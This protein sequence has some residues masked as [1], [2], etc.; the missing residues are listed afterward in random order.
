MACSDGIMY[1]NEVSCQTHGPLTAKVCNSGANAGKSYYG[2]Q[3]ECKKFIW[4]DG[5]TFQPINKWGKPLAASS[6]EVVKFMGMES[7]KPV[8]FPKRPAVGT[9]GPPAKKPAVTPTGSSV[10][11]QMLTDVRNT[12]FLKI[13]TLEARVAELESKLAELPTGAATEGEEEQ[14]VEEEQTV[15][16]ESK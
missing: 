4:I 8:T 7:P 3:K 11:S 2:C 13:T 6:K 14:P 1:G 9:K 5:E 10:T 15:P 16:E 12:L